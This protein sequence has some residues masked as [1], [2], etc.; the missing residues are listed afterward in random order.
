MKISPTYHYPTI[1]EFPIKVQQALE[2]KQ[3]STSMSEM[4]DAH[5]KRKEETDAINEQ[6]FS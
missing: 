6:T 2:M 3:I 5:E 4:N 1:N